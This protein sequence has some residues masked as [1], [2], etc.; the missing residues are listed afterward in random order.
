MC[1][2]VNLQAKDLVILWT[3]MQ[4]VLVTMVMSIKEVNM[5]TEADRFTAV[6]ELLSTVMATI[7]LHRHLT[8]MTMMAGY[9]LKVE[10]TE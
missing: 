3:E 2:I 4:I 10:V 7:V 9:D 1:T 5:A 6:N 8:M